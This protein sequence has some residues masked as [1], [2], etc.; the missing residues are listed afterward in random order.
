MLLTHGMYVQHK[1]RMHKHDTLFKKLFRNLRSVAREAAE[2]GGKICIEW[3]DGNDLWN[4]PQVQRMVKQYDLFPVKFD[5]CAVGL[6][7]SDGL[8]MRKNWKLMTNVPE[9]EGADAGFVSLPCDA[10]NLI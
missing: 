4:K 7:A 6:T 3:P 1:N 10:V 9:L 5:G 8:P 2:H